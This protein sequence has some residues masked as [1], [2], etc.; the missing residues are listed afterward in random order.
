MFL[1][2]RGA[3]SSSCAPAREGK[4]FEKLKK[5]GNFEKND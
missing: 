3:E 4:F 2:S 1:N 5:Q